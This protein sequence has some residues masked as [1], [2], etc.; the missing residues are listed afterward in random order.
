MHRPLLNRRRGG[1]LIAVLSVLALGPGPGLRAGGEPAEK[2]APPDKEAL[3]KAKELITKLYKDELDKA[4]GDAARTRGLA[5]ELL[6]QCRETTAKEEAPLRF[7]ALSLARHL[8]SQVGYHALALEAIE[9]LARAFTVDPLPMKADVLSGAAK[10]TEGKNT[11]LLLRLWPVQRTYG[12]PPCTGERMRE[13]GSRRSGIVRVPLTDVNL[14]R[15]EAAF[16]KK[17]RVTNK[18]TCPTVPL[19]PF[20]RRVPQDR[21]H[22]RRNGKTFLRKAV[23]E[24]IMPREAHQRLRTGTR[25]RTRLLSK[26][27]SKATSG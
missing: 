19:T 8:A 27:A 16:R 25:T 24:K 3:A 13:T 10:T 21:M 2:V 15:G 5:A 18:E 1:L 22:E 4:K 20:L 17:R 26:S 11:S 9:E 6:K 23:E 7:A 12:G 14:P